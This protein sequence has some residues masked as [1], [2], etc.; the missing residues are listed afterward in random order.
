MQSKQGPIEADPAPDRTIKEQLRDISDNSSADVPKE[1]AKIPEEEQKSA[2]AIKRVVPKVKLDK[3]L[4]K[5]ALNKAG[6]KGE[7]EP[8]KPDEQRLKV[9]HKKAGNK[10]GKEDIKGLIGQFM[11]ARGSLGSAQHRDNTDS[12]VQP[13]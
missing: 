11:Q 1:P 2:Q 3:A 7:S 9:P 13:L 8:A 10:I 4:L 6:E 5:L 12:V